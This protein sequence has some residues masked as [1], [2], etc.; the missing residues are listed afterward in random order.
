MNYF[1]IILYI[2]VIVDVLPELLSK[3]TLSIFK[4]PSANGLNKLI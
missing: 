1:V 2:I 4:S 3:N